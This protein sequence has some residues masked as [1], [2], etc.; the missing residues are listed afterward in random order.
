[1]VS[2]WRNLAG[3]HL[4]DMSSSLTGALSDASNTK[5]RELFDKLDLDHGG[6]LTVDELQKAI[7]ATGKSVS[8]AKVS[9]ML[10]A[11]DDECVRVT[12]LPLLNAGWE[13]WPHTHASSIA[14]SSP[15]TR[16]ASPLVLRC[17]CPQW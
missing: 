1:M 2:L 17:A 8:E 15:L 16:F 12:A 4:L 9:T 10:G 3:A 6:T 13:G 7:E 14:F 5:L 11:A